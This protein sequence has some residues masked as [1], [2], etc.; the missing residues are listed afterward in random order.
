MKKILLTTFVIAGLGCGLMPQEAQAN[1][2][3][4]VKIRQG[5]IT[6][7]TTSKKVTDFTIKEINKKP[8]PAFI[9][10]LSACILGGLGIVRGK[11]PDFF[12]GPI[13]LVFGIP[14]A[15]EAYTARKSRLVKKVEKTKSNSQ[16]FGS[17]V[18][19][20]FK[21]IWNGK[22]PDDAIDNTVQEI[23]TNIQIKKLI[24]KPLTQISK[25]L[26]QVIEALE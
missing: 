25:G 20:C 13:L 12:F 23:G 2:T 6:V 1:D 19:T 15:L 14:V 5:L 26:S 17:G 21:A 4:D 11:L 7:L 22:D 16:I 10:G 24:R 3:T 8:Q 18:K 9:L